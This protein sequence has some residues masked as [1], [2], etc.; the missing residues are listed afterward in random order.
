[1]R[2]AEDGRQRTED[3]GQRTEDRRWEEEAEML[4]RGVTNNKETKEQR[5]PI[6]KLKC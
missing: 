3:G 2:K 4:K 5:G 1:M 6:K